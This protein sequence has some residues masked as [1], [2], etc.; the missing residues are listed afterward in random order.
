[1]RGGR[2]MLL[3]SSTMALA[4]VSCSSDGVNVFC[5]PETATGCKSA[6]EG[7]GPLIGA[8]VVLVSATCCT[9]AA[10]AVSVDV[11]GAVLWA[12]RAAAGA[13]KIPAIANVE[14]ANIARKRPAFE[15]ASER[16]TSEE[17]SEGGVRAAF[18]RVFI[19]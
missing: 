7:A 5:S 15:R 13:P 11:L 12:A 3:P 17:R 1:A 10:A 8:V 19:T 2:F 18:I 4:L 14:P 6:S 9:T 16:G